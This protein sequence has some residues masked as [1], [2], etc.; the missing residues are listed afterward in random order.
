MRTRSRACR[1]RKVE[2]LEGY[3]Y[4]EVNTFAVVGGEVCFVIA[5]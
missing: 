3:V 1:R 4:H 5:Y 2:L